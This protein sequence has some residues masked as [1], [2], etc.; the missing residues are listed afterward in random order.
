MMFD[1]LA[2]YYIFTLDTHMVYANPEILLT[3]ISKW[4]WWILTFFYNEKKRISEV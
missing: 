4:I 3:H 1:P 2:T